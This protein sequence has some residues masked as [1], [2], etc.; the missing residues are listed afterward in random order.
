MESSV[1]EE[2][3]FHK[4]MKN[5][6]FGLVVSGEGRERKVYYVNQMAYH[7]LGYTREEYIKKVQGGWS[8]FLDI[9]LREV[10]RDHHEEILTGEPFE[11]TALTETKDGN[12][13]WLSFRV[14]VSM[15]LK[16]VSY[17]TITDVTEKVEKNRRYAR[18]REYLKDCAA[19]DSMTR[20]LNRGTMEERIK[21][22]LEAVEEGQNYAYIALDLDNFKQINDMY[23]HWAGDSIIMGISNILREVYGNNARIGRM[24]GDEFAVFIP[25]V[26]DRAQIQS[27]AD[28]VL[29]RLRLQKEMIGM[30]EEPTASIG[31][32]FGPEDGRSFRELYHR[33]DEALYQVKNEEK[34]SIAI[35]TM[36]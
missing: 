30:A 6:P 15:E 22:E 14:M 36:I 33:A 26:K 13:K 17:I 21:E 11:L 29:R 23:G 2:K 5:V 16:P 4:V 31:I 27:Q 18:E 20:L 25:D 3:V 19:R 34:D 10:M 1:L 8:R 7:M 12:K 28:E 32:A 35:Y 24:G 9:D